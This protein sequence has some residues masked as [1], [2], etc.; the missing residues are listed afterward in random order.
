MVGL[1]EVAEFESATGVFV[2]MEDNVRV[3]IDHFIQTAF[4][5]LSRTRPRRYRS[6]HR[7]AARTL[8]QSGTR[9]STNTP[10]F[11]PFIILLAPNEYAASFPFRDFST[12][13]CKPC[14]TIVWQQRSFR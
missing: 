3:I 13:P 7:F 14:E 9:L 8:V 12:L 5:I 4:P 1:S 10:T 2:W 11:F 6:A